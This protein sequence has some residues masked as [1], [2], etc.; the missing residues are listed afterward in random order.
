MIGARTR[1]VVLAITALSM[2]RV[3]AQWQG[4]RTP[5]IPRNGDGTA[6]LNAQAPK[7]PDGHPDLSGIW[8]APRI[9]ALDEL[10]DFNMKFIKAVYGDMFSGMNP[11][12]AGPMSAMVPGGPKTS[13]FMCLGLKDLPSLKFVSAEVKNAS[14]V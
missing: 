13:Y 4:Y 14:T 9:A 8:M 11:Q 3:S 5:G 10:Q 12:Q 7:A 2:V 6:N 1:I